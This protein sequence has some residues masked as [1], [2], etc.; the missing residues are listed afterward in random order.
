MKPTPMKPTPI[1]R[2]EMTTLRHA[3]FDAEVHRNRVADSWRKTDP[4]HAKVQRAQAAKIEKL[5]DKLRNADGF[6]LE[7]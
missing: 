1:T 3:L 6:V 4:E 7:G 5:R 2:D